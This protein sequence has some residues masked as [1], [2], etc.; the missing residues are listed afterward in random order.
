[1]RATERERETR[2]QGPGTRGWVGQDAPKHNTHT[3][4]R[5]V[6]GLLQGK[7]KKAL[8]VFCHDAGYIMGNYTRRIMERITNESRQPRTWVSGKVLDWV[9]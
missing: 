7:K 1:M 5:T 4:R 3:Q 8:V 2:D 6:R 9:A